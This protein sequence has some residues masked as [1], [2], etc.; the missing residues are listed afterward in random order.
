MLLAKRKLKLETERL[1][2]RPPTHSDFRGWTTL[3]SDSADYLIPWEPSWAVDHLTRKSFTNRVYWAQ[4]SING[5][6]AL[7]LFLIGFA[8]VGF[9]RQRAVR[10]SRAAIEAALDEGVRARRRLVDRRNR[11]E[12]PAT[13]EKNGEHRRGDRARRDRNQLHCLYSIV[14]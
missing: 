2:L 10:V 5:G 6:T 13:A 1:T 14:S 7:P 3:R 12:K 4:R 11:G 9:E 8:A